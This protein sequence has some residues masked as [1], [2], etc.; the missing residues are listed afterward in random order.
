VGAIPKDCQPAQQK[1]DKESYTTSQEQSL[2]LLYNPEI[3]TLFF[4]PNP[5]KKS[6]DYPLTNGFYE[7]LKKDDYRPRFSLSFFIVLDNVK[8]TR[9]VFNLQ[10]C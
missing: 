7:S 5:A 1:K 6:Y 10:D 8:I 9:K 3:G 4:T 2:K